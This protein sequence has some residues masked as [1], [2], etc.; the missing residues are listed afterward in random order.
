MGWVM[1]LLSRFIY[2]ILSLTLE[3]CHL[4]DQIDS[5]DVIC[6][7][8]ILFILSF[9][10]YILFTG[11]Q[12]LCSCLLAVITKMKCKS[13][14]WKLLCVEITIQKT[15]IPKIWTVLFNIIG[16]PWR[17]YGIRAG[18][19]WNKLVFKFVQRNRSCTVILLLLFCRILDVLHICVHV[20]NKLS[21][22]I[23]VIIKIV[24]V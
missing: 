23:V 3:I 17:V 1:P 11:L 13:H 4:G 6:E 8:I 22:R 10:I 15:G 19:K 16:S 2:Y 7:E 12:S 21:K 20:E 9:T 5:N 18:N 14:P 24:V